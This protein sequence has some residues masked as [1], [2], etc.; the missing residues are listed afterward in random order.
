MGIEVRL[1]IRQRSHRSVRVV[2]QSHLK[3]LGRVSVERLVRVPPYSVIAVDGDNCHVESAWGDG[4]ME[5]LSAVDT[6]RYHVHI[7]EKG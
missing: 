7:V 6:A 2:L 3:E 5:G 4:N 1:W